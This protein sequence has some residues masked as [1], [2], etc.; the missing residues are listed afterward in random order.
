MSRDGSVPQVHVLQIDDDF[1]HAFGLHGNVSFEV[2]AQGGLRVRGKQRKRQ[3]GS[4]SEAL[5]VLINNPVGFPSIFDNVLTCPSPFDPTNQSATVELVCT[6]QL[7]V[8]AT[9]AMTVNMTSVGTMFPPSITDLS[10]SAPTNAN[11]VGNLNT[12]VQLQ[13]SVTV[14]DLKL[15]TLSFAPFSIG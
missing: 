6:G 8:N 14:V 5:P 13:G 3:N 2:H 4:G 7:D 10:F 11:I 15:E 12:F 9:F 1:E